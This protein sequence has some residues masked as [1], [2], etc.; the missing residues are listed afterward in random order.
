[1][2]LSLIKSAPI[3]SKSLGTCCNKI[4]ILNSKP[5]ALNLKVKKINLTKIL[6][7]SVSLVTI[8]LKMCDYS[9]QTYDLMT[10]FWE[11]TYSL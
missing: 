9:A 3:F 11:A 6:P 10:C 7:P 2:D 5:S 1:M 8:E 4:E